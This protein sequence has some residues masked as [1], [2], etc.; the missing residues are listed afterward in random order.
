MVTPP[1]ISRVSRKASLE[2]QEKDEMSGLI[3]FPQPLINGNVEE[4]AIEPAPLQVAVAAPAKPRKMLT[5]READK[6]LKA[7]AKIEDAD[8]SDV[9]ATGFQEQKE[10][11]KHRSQKRAA[12]V[13][14]GE[15]HKRKV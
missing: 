6:I 9:E 7:I 10:L 2:Y 14:E 11:F 5:D 12:A 13:E 4:Q 1:Q 8:Y 3:D 15:L